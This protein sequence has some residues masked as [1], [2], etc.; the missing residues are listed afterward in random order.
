MKYYNVIFSSTSRNGTAG[1]QPRVGFFDADTIIKLAHEE[2]SKVGE[3]FEDLL[4]V[5]WTETD[6]GDFIPTRELSQEELFAGAVRKL[7]DDGRLFE[8]Y[9]VDTEN[10]A[11]DDRLLEL[12][13]V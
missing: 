4:N 11:F 8:V 6:T 1:L 7:G 10:A 9:E 12:L 5:P 3:S 13:G 2:L